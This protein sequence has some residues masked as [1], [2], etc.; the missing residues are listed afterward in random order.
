M[1]QTGLLNKSLFWLL[2]RLQQRFHLNGS[3]FAPGTR[4]PLGFQGTT[5]TSSDNY[6][7]F[8]NEGYKRNNVVYS[9]IN[10]IATAAQKIGF[11]LIDLRTGEEIPR[12]Q[13]PTNLEPLRRIL[14]QPNPNE[15]MPEYIA[16]WETILQLAGITYHT[17][18]GAGQDEFVGA[19]PTAAEL[20]LISPENV[21]VKSKGLRL[22][23]YKV[24][25]G[26]GEIFL[27]PEQMTNIKYPDP[28]SEFDG[29]SPTE[30]AAVAIDS[31]NS[32]MAWNKNLLENFGVPAGILI[33][34]Q[35]GSITV[36]QQTILR[37]QWESQFAGSKRAGKI[38]VM[39]AEGMEYN[40]ISS[41][42]KE[43]EWRGGLEDNAR[44]ICNVYGVPS[45]LIGDPQTSKFSN[46]K[47]ALRAL[48]QDKVIPDMLHFAAEQTEFLMPKFGVEDQI[49]IGLDKSGVEVLLDDLNEQTERLSKAT[50][51]KVN[52]KRNQQNLDDDPDGDVILQSASEV[53]LGTEP[54]A[55]PT[56][57]ASARSKP[58][59]KIHPLSH[60]PTEEL[61]QAEFTRRDSLRKEWEDRWVKKLESIFTEQRK[62]FIE[63]FLKAER[64]NGTLEKRQLGDDFAQQVFDFN[65]ENK[66]MKD[67]LTTLMSSLVVEFGQS[68]I[69]QAEGAGIIFNIER[70]GIQQFIGDSLSPV[71]REINRTT[72]NQLT[73]VI[74]QGIDANEGVFKIRDRITDKFD[75]ISTGRARTIAQTE[76]GR[77]SGRATLEGF[78]QVSP[79]L[80]K[81]WISSRDGLV[82]DDPDVSHVFMDGQVVDMPDFFVGPSGQLSQQ[83][84]PTSGDPGFDINCRCVMAALASGEEP[85]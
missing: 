43:M 74:N 48:Y 69:D 7:A 72:T 15:S 67:E 12:D 62:R 78:N 20:H 22:I 41:T 16:R 64:S 57:A 35:Q 63:A 24:Q 51:M 11:T 27:T 4:I 2:R 34:K 37:N 54:A 32:G 8:V 77:A 70:P 52:E 80:Q 19:V 17:I 61:R 84:P 29:Q 26:E 18:L 31:Y 82:R 60:F 6:I 42:G 49:G 9:C 58:A 50:W 33:I 85:I 46:Y 13:T 68:A 36:D 79:N 73:N 1:T 76:V 28:L 23:G 10:L 65:N 81:E 30:P 75:Q 21:T 83:V 56:G 14:D 25:T 47:V 53:P 5:S 45:Q 38:A 40:D 66:I 44:R 39:G 71:V 55:P 3:G 59:N